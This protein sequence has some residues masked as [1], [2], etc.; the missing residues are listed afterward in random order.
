MFGS[1]EL[2]VAAVTPFAALKKGNVTRSR[3]LALDYLTKSGSHV[4]SQSLVNGHLALAVILATTFVASFL[5]IVIP[6]LYTHHNLPSI[7][8]PTVLQMDKFDA[9]DVDISF[10]DKGAA[11]MLNLL[12]Y[13]DVKYPQWVHD[14]LTLPQFASPS[15]AT[16]GDEA[17]AFTARSSLQT[18]A[19]RARLQCE[20]VT[21]RTEWM[22]YSYGYAGLDRDYSE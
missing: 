5:S 18:E 8:N 4:F 22:S 12:T 20:S 10:D 16:E 6:G 17:E 15:L 21:K 14:D 11:T 7:N 3:S 19:M 9:S 1:I 2:T 13:Y